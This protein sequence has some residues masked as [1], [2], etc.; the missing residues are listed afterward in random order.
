MFRSAFLRK[1]QLMVNNINKETF[2]RSNTARKSIVTTST[3]CLPLQL[4]CQLA[5]ET[6]TKN[7]QNSDII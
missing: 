1:Y 2:I 7:L 3:F 5:K 6:S 4:E